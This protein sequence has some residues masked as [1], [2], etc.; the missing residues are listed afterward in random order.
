MIHIFRF[1]IFLELTEEK[2]YKNIFEE[3]QP[4]TTKSAKIICYILDT[5]FSTFA[6][7]SGS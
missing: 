1:N 5:H 2:S 7:G 6:L 4:K 3:K